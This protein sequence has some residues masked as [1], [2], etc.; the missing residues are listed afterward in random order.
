MKKNLWKEGQ[1]RF[2]ILCLVISYNTN[3]I[4]K[5]TQFKEMYRKNCDATIIFLKAKIGARTAILKKNNPSRRPNTINNGRGRRC[6]PLS[7]VVRRD[8]DYS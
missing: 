4:Q 2:P 1:V 3:D 8:T 5:W 6:R 7:L